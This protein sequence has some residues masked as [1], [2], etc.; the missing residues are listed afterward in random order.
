M[1][2]VCPCCVRLE[3]GGRKRVSNHERDVT[4]S[5]TRTNEKAVLHCCS[6]GG[7]QAHELGQEPVHPKHTTSQGGPLAGYGQTEV[8]T[9]SSEVGSLGLAHRGIPWSGRSGNPLNRFRAQLYPN[10]THFWSGIVLERLHTRWTNI[11]LCRL[12]LCSG[13]L[14]CTLRSALSLP[15]CRCLPKRVRA[16]HENQRSRPQSTE[17]PPPSAW[18]PECEGP[19]DRGDVWGLKYDLK[20]W[21]GS[22]PRGARRCK[23][24][25]DRTRCGAGH[26]PRSGRGPRNWTSAHALE[27]SQ[28]APPW[29]QGSRTRARLALHCGWSGSPPFCLTGIGADDGGGGVVWE[30]TPPALR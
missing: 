19:P 30:T 21:V 25:F 27:G 17:N 1:A 10:P 24:V 8:R 4:F 18:W 15:S 28:T 5:S 29:R 6:S 23:V 7:L 13:E 3:K 2:G 22:V 12:G 26:V 20:P 16:V 9:T 11:T 14:Q